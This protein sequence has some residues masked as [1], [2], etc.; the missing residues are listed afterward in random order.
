VKLLRISILAFII[1][2]LFITPSLVDAQ[3]SYSAGTYGACEYNTC[4]ITF[5]SGG[6]VTMNVTPTIGSTTCTTASDELQVMTDSSTGYTLSMTDTDTDTD[7]VNGTGVTIATTS[8]TSASPAALSA[9]EWGYRVDGIGAF[10]S[11]PTTGAANT[12]IPAV[13]FATIP[14]SAGTAAT[15]ATS[16]V[17]ANPYVSTFVW[18]GLCVDT[19]PQSGAYSDSVTYTAVVN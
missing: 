1:G 10:G 15:L 3:S 8:A 6:T 11:G 13:T 12:A 16:N 4:G 2:G 18:Y 7:L 17:A 5:G 19:T 14:S 9:N